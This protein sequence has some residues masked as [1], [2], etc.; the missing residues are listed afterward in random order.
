MPAGLLS[1]WLWEVSTDTAV[2]TL[3]KTEAK[4]QPLSGER[5]EEGNEDTCS[6]P[7]WGTANFSR[8]N[9]SRPSGPTDPTVLRKCQKSEAVS[10]KSTQGWSFNLHEPWWPYKHPGG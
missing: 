4:L 9:A 1:G 7:K 6:F 10:S 3:G 5:T 2:L 8:N